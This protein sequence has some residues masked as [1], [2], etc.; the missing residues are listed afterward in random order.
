MIYYKLLIVTGWSA[1]TLSCLSVVSCDDG[2][3]KEVERDS[4]VEAR[5]A[6]NDASGSREDSAPSKGGDAGKKPIGGPSTWDPPIDIP[7][8]WDP[9]DECGSL[10]EPCVGGDCDGDAQCNYDIAI[11]VAPRMNPLTDFGCDNDCPREFP[12]CLHYSCMTF[13][14]ASCFCQGLLGSQDRRCAGGPELALGLCRGEGA[15][16]SKESECCGDLS[17]VEL[18]P[19]RRSCYKVCADSDE[20]DSGCCTDFKDLG[21]PL[22]APIEECENPCKKR[23]EICESASECCLG[24][25]VTDTEVPDWIGCRPSCSDDSDCFTGCCF[26]FKDSDR[27]FCTA[28]KFC[29]CGGE[30]AAC[31]SIEPA[32]C[33]GYECTSDSSG[34]DSFSCR[35]T[36]DEDAD[37]ASNCCV[38]L[39]GSDY[40][41]C[42]DQGSDYCR[43]GGEGAACGADEPSCCE[44]Y[45]CIVDDSESGSSSCK[46]RCQVDSD[47]ADNCCIPVS[48]TDYGVCVDESYCVSG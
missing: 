2:D 19:G 9:P 10:G 33:E 5:D 41:V 28:E 11:C 44:A 48:G 27:G 39:T 7:S 18:A 34:G 21:S 32:C 8:R 16:C 13:K 30:G 1:V 4:G 37:C 47:C 29:G 36:C 46:P 17:C 20:C 42:F 22:C 15:G 26:L 23:G 3:E 31:G 6:S 45:E 24:T 43:C 35:P 38:P 25:C 14:E 12:Y 40:G